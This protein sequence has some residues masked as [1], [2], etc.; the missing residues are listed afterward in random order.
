MVATERRSDLLVE[1]LDALVELKKA[2]GELGD[3]H[4]RHLL[5]RQFDVLT[6]GGGQ[7]AGG[8]TGGVSHLP[9]AQPLGQAGLTERRNRFG[10]AYSVSKIS[11]PLWEE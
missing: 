4:L 7:S 1:A 2:P 3:D 10:L 9:A 11:A 8:D 5:A 6:A